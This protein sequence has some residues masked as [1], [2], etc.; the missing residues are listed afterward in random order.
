MAM[1]ASQPK[2]AVFLWPALQRP[3]LAAR[4]REGLGSPTVASTV[5]APLAG[6]SG[7]FWMMRVFITTPRRLRGLAQPR[8][9]ATAPEDGQL[10]VTGAGFWCPGGRLRVRNAGT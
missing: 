2:I 8:S 10:A 4:L 5:W 7:S 9:H 3:I 1:N 6:S